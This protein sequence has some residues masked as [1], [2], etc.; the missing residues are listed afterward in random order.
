MQMKVCFSRLSFGLQSDFCCGV[1]LNTLNRETGFL[2]KKL[3]A[4]ITAALPFP[5][6][7]FFDGLGRTKSNA[8]SS[9]IPPLRLSQVIENGTPNAT[10]PP[11]GTPL[12]QAPQSILGQS[13]PG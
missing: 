2:E 1:A 9:P 7:N 11:P 6:T 12:R 4:V 10:L 5:H 8:Q 3:L 13:L